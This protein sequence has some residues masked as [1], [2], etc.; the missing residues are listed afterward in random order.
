V[1]TDAMAS[2]LSKEEEET[3]KGI[4]EKAI[5]NKAMTL[6]IE[7]LSPDDLPITITMS[8]WMRRM[9]DMAKTGGGGG[10]SF[11]GSMPDNYNVAVNGNHPII[12]RILKAESEDQKAKLAKQAYDLGLLSQSMLT[13][14]DLTAFIKRSVELVG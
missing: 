4:F 6:A 5:N 13:G 10:M 11:M 7:S 3:V 8:E 1:K 14:A 9:K 2:V 12:Q